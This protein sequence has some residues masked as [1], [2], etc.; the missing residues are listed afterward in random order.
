[1][2]RVLSI[3]MGVCGVCLIVCIVAFITIDVMNDDNGGTV[4]SDFVSS[5]VQVD[6]NEEYEFDNSYKKTEIDFSILDVMLEEYKDMYVENSDM[7]GYI[8]LDDKHEYPVVQS[9]SDQNYY[10]KRNFEGKEDKNG[11]IFEDSVSDLSKSNVSI[12]FGHNMK[13]GKM[14]GDLDDYKDADYVE[15]HKTIELDTLYEKYQYE[16]AAVAIVNANADF[17]YCEYVHLFTAKDLQE[18]KIGFSR[19]LVY[20]NLDVITLNDHVVELSTCSYE[21]DNDRLIVILKRL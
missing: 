3:I 6:S 11:C 5:F 17:N 7:V 13:S 9:K 20:G 1:M 18:W 4:H 10:L 15:S 12:I 14:F 19:Y 8:K 2:K 16:V 21:E